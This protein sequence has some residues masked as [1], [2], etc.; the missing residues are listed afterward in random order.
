[1]RSWFRSLL[2]CAVGVMLLGAPGLAQAQDGT[3]VYTRIANWQIARLNWDDYA[4]DFKKNTLPVLEKLLADG[5]LTEYGLMSAVV[6]TPDG[7][8]HSSWWSARTIADVEKALAA[9]EA[10]ARK[11]PAA[12]RKRGDTD[13]VGT[14]HSDML[15]RSR[16]V[17]GRT[18]K[19]TDGYGHI[20][21]DVVQ[22]GRGQDYDQNYEKNTRPTYDKLFAD[23]TVTTFGIDT[24]YIHTGH[25]GARTRWY[26]VATADGLDK[27]AAAGAAATQARSAAEREA[28]A[29]AMRGV[30]DGAAHRDELW[31]V[32][33]F[34]SKY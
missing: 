15:V 33:A 3:I 31:R 20:A 26:I 13:F 8:T 30:T 29:V 6:H 24:E 1:M 9:L 16:V 23:G 7:Y 18:T 27:V 11:L 14:K 19:L 17:R 22:P 21:I 5:V 10:A 4:A 12:E 34:A 25:P 32:L 28:I 2:L